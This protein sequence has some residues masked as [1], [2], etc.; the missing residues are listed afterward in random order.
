MRKGSIKVMVGA[1]GIPRIQEELGDTIKVYSHESW[2]EELAKREKVE[3]A[4]LEAKDKQ[5]SKG[6]KAKESEAK[7]VKPKA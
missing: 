6:V 7:V 3:K 2:Q 5:E 4:E 1:N